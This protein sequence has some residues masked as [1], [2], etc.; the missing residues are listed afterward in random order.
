MSDNDHHL[1]RNFNLYAAI[2]VVVA[3]IPT[4]VFADS[5][6]ADRLNQQ[7]SRSAP[8]LAELNAYATARMAEIDREMARKAQNPTVWSR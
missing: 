6:A 3:A 7:S 1:D 4:I 8:S 2:A 5:L